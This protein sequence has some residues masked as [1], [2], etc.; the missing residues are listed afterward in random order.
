[1]NQ[2]EEAYLIAEEAQEILDSIKSRMETERGHVGYLVETLY[3][4]EEWIEKFDN[5]LGFT[6]YPEH[7]N[8]YKDGLQCLIE[9]CNTF[10][11]R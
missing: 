8:R 1:M 6:M 4:Y 5:I 10:G 2:I 9:H 7:H 11:E 3:Y